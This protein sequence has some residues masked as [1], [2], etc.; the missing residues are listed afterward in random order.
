VLQLQKQLLQLLLSVLSNLHPRETLLS[1]STFNEQIKFLLI[2]VL[3]W[4]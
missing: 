3:F 4:N 2:K 1:A